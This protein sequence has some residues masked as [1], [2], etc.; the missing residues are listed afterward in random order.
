[1]K[2]KKIYLGEKYRRYLGLKH[3]INL[4]FVWIWR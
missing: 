2:F 3:E 1:M 4:I